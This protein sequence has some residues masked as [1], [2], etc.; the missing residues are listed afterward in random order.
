MTEARTPDKP[1]RT[2]EKPK[3]K[4]RPFVH[5][6]RATGIVIPDKRDGYPGVRDFICTR[7][8][9][10]RG[11]V[12]GLSDNVMKQLLKDMKCRCRP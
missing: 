1:R 9:E 11:V 10:R 4:P 6:W 12:E 5:A 2:V 8:K 7:C 3:A